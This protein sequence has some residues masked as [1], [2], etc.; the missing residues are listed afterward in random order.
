[1][2]TGRDGRIVF[3]SGSYRSRREKE[4]QLMA[5]KAAERVRASRVPFSFDSMS[6]N[7][8]RI[9]H[10]ALIE[11]KSVRTESKGDGIDRKVIVYP[12]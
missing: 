12:A 2:E 1:R 5:A 6:P 8:R 10:T 11:D 7:E 9:V 3:D 4:L